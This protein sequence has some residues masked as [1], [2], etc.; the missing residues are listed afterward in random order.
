MPEEIKLPVVLD[1]KKALSQLKSFAS[2][3]SSALS[4]IVSSLTSVKTLVAGGL[5]F[6]AL[7]KTI[8]SLTSAASRQQDAI[9]N[10]NT[11]LR[12]SG[13]F[14]KEASKDFQDY[15]SSIQ[16]VTKFGDEAVLEQLALA[17]AFG[18][19]NEQAKQVTSAAIELSAATGKSLEEA[20]RQVSKTLGG[21]AGELGEVN[22]AIKALTAE[23]LKA[24]EAARILIEQYGGSAAAQVNTF[25]GAIAQTSNLFGDLQESLGRTIIEN[26]KVIAAIKGIGEAFKSIISSINSNEG[27]IS[28]FIG[29]A[30]SS[31][32][33]FAP[34]AVRS[35]KIIPQ[36]ILGIKLAAD[37]A[38]IAG[39]QLI[40]AFL[41][42]DIISTVITNSVIA[43]KAL[44]AGLLD[45]I[46]LIPGLDFEGEL[47]AI[48]DSITGDDL[49]DVA[50]VKSSL[51]EIKQEALQSSSEAS[52]F[53]KDI[54]TAIETTATATENITKKIEQATKGAEVEI[55]PVVKPKDAKDFLRDF[56]DEIK[57][58][59]ALITKSLFSGGAGAKNLFVEGGTALVEELAP[60]FGK[61]A[62]PILDAL[63]KG[64]EFARSMIQGFVDELPTLFDNI[65]QAAPVIIT[66]LAENTDEII[67]AIAKGAPAIA[68]ALAIEVPLALANPIL[69]RDVASALVVALVEEITGV[70]VKFD[71]EKLQEILGNFIGNIDE[72][73]TKFTNSFNTIFE[74]FTGLLG[75]IQEVFSSFSTSIRSALN[76]AA[77]IDATDIE[78]KLNKF[79]EDFKTA[80]KPLI[81]PIN[82]LI[83]SIRPLTDAI[84]S[85]SDAFS[86]RGGGVIGAISS[87][88]VG[89]A[90]SQITG[91]AVSFS[92]GGTIPN[93]FP[94]D[95]FGPARL[96][97]GEIVVPKDDSK[98]LRSFL[99]SQQNNKGNNNAE[100]NT[101]ILG[102]IMESLD[103][104][105]SNSVVIDL[106]QQALAESILI[107]NKQ[108]ARL[109]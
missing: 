19:T 104:L 89:G 24:G 3:G 77:K 31:L 11:A 44:A 72:Q 79:G 32:A 87:G 18:A 73:I 28:D 48:E 101:A 1:T 70:T 63:S 106:D 54:E 80:L 75:K 10:L 45:I 83:S 66:T 71:S 4:S 40:E 9:N 43:V 98:M 84:Q 47:K 100:A 96:T 22:P 102:R 74:A 78:R 16:D 33:S 86:G 55:K 92:E 103:R 14:S 105:A 30:V 108:N 95:T 15:A 56:G 37:K 5:G 25:S 23:Q 46:N 39:I 53:F 26:P 52:K 12:T 65:A 21:F 82:E 90:V 50:S 91:G 60:G 107:L 76:V 36:A 109:N 49:I 94:N 58:G 51:N 6:F 61:A 8:S 57:K 59:S 81:D 64:P 42:F 69:W 17:K 29:D 13:E 38:K 35:I 20:T 41:E 34:S 27:S 93:G 68:R 97:S 85:A 7:G 62:Q 67:I 99:E 2:K 88:D